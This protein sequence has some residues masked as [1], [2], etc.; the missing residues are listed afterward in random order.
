MN[1]IKKF[2]SWAFS[3]DES[4]KLDNETIA[5]ERLDEKIDEEIDS[6]FNNDDDDTE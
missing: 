1:I 5:Q 6:A 2:F 4:Q 3:K